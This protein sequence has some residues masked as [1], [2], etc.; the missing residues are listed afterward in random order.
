[1]ASHTPF[2]SMGAYWSEKKSFVGVDLRA[3]ADEA[4]IHLLSTGRKRIAFMA[5]HNSGLLTSGVRYEAYAEAMAAAGFET[6]TV[7]SDSGQFG[8]IR[9]SIRDMLDSGL[10]PEAILCLSD[11][12][13]LAV[14]FAFQQFGVKPGADIALVGFDGLEETEHCPVPITTVR[15]PR[16]EMC[17]LTFSFL[18]DQ[19]EDPT[20]P[21]QQRILKP[22][23]MIRE[24]TS[25]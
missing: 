20:A 6:M 19:M 17:E 4:M 25:C 15:Q 1:M 11:D 16:E 18:R 2:V 23:L 7:G 24:S 22:E 3:G 12:I 21:L 10:R 5:P 13:A 9:T 14:S 8:D